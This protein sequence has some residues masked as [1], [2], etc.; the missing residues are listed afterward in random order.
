[1]G[2]TIIQSDLL[3]R[4]L[5]QHTK[6]VYVLLIRVYLLSVLVDTVQMRLGLSA[7]YSP[8][9]SMYKPCYLLSM[10]QCIIIVLSTCVSSFCIS[11]QFEADRRAFIITINSFGTALNRDD[12]VKLYPTIGKLHPDG[13]IMLSKASDYDEVRQVADNYKVQY[14]LYGLFHLHTYEGLHET[15]YIRCA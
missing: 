15:W 6:P 11:P 2:C 4:Y 10:F 13:L 1:M 9:R 7:V 5:E 14:T 3:S 8:A 12:R